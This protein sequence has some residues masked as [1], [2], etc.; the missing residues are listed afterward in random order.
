MFDVFDYY[1]TAQPSCRLRMKSDDCLDLW[2]DPR[3][4]N[5]LRIGTDLA[6]LEDPLAA[7]ALE[8]MGGVAPELAA[9][10][11]SCVLSA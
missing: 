6:H 11:K 8:M 10:A 5:L 2:V 1:D 4:G 3:V 9:S 7:E